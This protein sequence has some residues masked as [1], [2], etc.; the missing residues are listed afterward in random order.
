M[1]TL[2]PIV[3]EKDEVIGVKTREACGPDDIVRVSGLFVYNSKR[4][5]LI[6][7]RAVTKQYDPGKWSDAVAGT[8]EEDETYESNII[9]EAEEEIGL[10]ITPGDIHEVYHGLFES[11]HQIFYTQYV[12]EVNQPIDAFQRKEDEVAELRW[13]LFSELRQWVGER[14]E[15]FGAGMK[16]VLDIIEKALGWTNI[17]HAKIDR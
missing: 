8:V 4:E 17:D 15:D 7:K 13:V 6:A 12:T 16:E 5:V 3:N 9:K 1:P 11:S 2:L 10:R 14:P